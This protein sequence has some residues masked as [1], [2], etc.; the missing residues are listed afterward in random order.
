L[1]KYPLDTFAG[2]FILI[3]R[4]GI[5]CLENDY[6]AETPSIKF[7]LEAVNSE[8]VGGKMYTMRKNQKRR[9]F[10]Q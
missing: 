10:T 6:K 8:A 1:E 5:K 4:R 2:I 9:K 7:I 3:R